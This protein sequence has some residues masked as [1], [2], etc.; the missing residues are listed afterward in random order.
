MI[1]KTL[2]SARARGLLPFMMEDAR[3]MTRAMG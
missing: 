2:A 1:R 3:T